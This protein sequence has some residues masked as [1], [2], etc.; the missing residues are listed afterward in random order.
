[1]KYL[2]DMAPDVMS[3]DA[4]IGLFTNYERGSFRGQY[5]GVPYCILLSVDRDTLESEP[6][7]AASHPGTCYLVG[8]RAA[9]AHQLAGANLLLGTTNSHRSQRGQMGDFTP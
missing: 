5:N 4:C 2:D 8:L 7:M 9:T 6:K 3:W 1:M